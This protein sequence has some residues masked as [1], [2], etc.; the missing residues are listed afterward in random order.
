MTTVETK[1]RPIIFSAPM[2]RAI[3]DGKKTQ[4]RRIVKTPR[5]N[6]RGDDGKPCGK[7][8]FDLSRAWVDP[9][10]E[11]RGIHS[12][13][14]L[15][16]PYAHPQDGWQKDP[17]HDAA[18]RIYCPYGSPSSELWVKEAF[19]ADHLDYSNGGSLP[20]ERPDWADEM[21][22]YRADGECCDQIPECACAEVGKPRWR[23]PIHM[24]RW[25]SR[26]TLWIESVRVER[27]QDISEADA[28][29]EG[30]GIEMPH[31]WA[32]RKDPNKVHRTATG[33]FNTSWNML[34]GPQNFE[35]V[36]PWVWVLTFS[37]I[38]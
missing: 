9:G 38:K 16:V 25:A 21:L 3:L 15:K 11:V 13:Q 14:Y 35:K 2:I 12:G 34:N 4:T 27:V 37:R 33:C 32:V 22:Y 24:P 19:Y 1:S 8:M 29:A 17:S 6:A 5:S 18:E 20:K 7:M 31:C 28:I 30:T 10:W 26:I 36:N 23:S